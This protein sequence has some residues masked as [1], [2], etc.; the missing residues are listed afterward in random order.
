[1][2]VDLRADNKLNALDDM[3]GAVLSIMSFVIQQLPSVQSNVQLCF[4]VASKPNVTTEGSVPPL[5]SFP[6]DANAVFLMNG[7]TLHPL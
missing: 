7:S 6:R 2:H 4:I 5:K 1:V 3:K